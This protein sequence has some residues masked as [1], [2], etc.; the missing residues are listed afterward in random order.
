MKVNRIDFSLIEM[1]FRGRRFCV[2]SLSIENTD[3]V[4]IKRQGDRISFLFKNG[5]F[6]ELSFDEAMVIIK[7]LKPLLK[8]LKDNLTFCD[9]LNCCI[10]LKYKEI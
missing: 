2:L 8:D 5:D 6:K 9:I 1:M 10:S 7:K 4:E 3:S